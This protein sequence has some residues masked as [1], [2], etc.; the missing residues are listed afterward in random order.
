MNSERQQ[1]DV[2]SVTRLN[3][4]VKAVLE[5]SFPTLW[6]KGE[7][8]NFAQPASG[9]WYFSLK[10][11]HSQVRCAMFRGRNRL[12][13]FQPENGDEVLLQVSVSLYEGRGEF[14][15]I[16]EH[17]E[18]AGEGAL[19]K[20]FDALKQKLFK[21]GLFSDDHKQALPEYPAS[22]G[23]ITSA[24]G[25]AL[26]DILHVLN[27]R[28]P[29]CTAIVYPVPVQGD[30]AAEQ[31]RDMLD[32]AIQRNETDV[33]IIA[34]GGGSMEDLWAFNDESLARAI[35]ACPIP[36]VSGIG[37]EID[38][39]IADFVADVRAPTPSAAAELVC[40]DSAAIAHSLKQFES[41]LGKLLANR[42]YE[43]TMKL[44]YLSRKIL[45]FDNRLLHYQNRLQMTQ[46]QLLSN[47]ELLFQQRKNRLEL[48]KRTIISKNPVTH[49]KSQSIRLQNTERRLI[50]AY[51]QSNAR[52]QDQLKFLKRS[53]NM[54]NPL[55][56]LHRGYSVL[57]NTDGNVIQNIGQ[58]AIDDRINITLSDGTADATII[59]KQKKP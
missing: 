14:Q 49:L 1:F 53:L 57:K 56:V 9:H 51:F 6:V 13:K 59:D 46:K 58:L 27:R 8:S 47:I 42:L 40:P 31:I 7:L 5:G 43:M 29:H 55:A 52:L 50:T 20:A 54:I 12:L 18:L 4:E 32:T 38:F 2:Y 10:D 24:T 45:A 41:K 28:F 23:I 17:M 3:R 11:S 34:R 25:A 15:L 22:I 39:T 36:L 35:H 44:D 19:Q 33:I 48:S 21:E 16:V 30:G 37:H 26:R